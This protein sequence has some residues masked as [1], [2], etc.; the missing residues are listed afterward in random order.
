MLEDSECLDNSSCFSLVVLLAA[1]A[2]QNAV[3]IKA[4]ALLAT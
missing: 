1:L 4:F 2:N 3:R